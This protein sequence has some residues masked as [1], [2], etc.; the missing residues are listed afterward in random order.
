MRSNLVASRSVAPVGVVEV[1]LAPAGV[2][3]RSPAGGPRRRGRSRPRSRPAGS[4][5]RGCAR[6]RA[7]RA[8][9]PSRPAVAEAAPRAAP[10]DP[11]L[12]VG[13]V[14]KAGG[15][16][17]S[18]SARA[19]EVVPSG[20]RSV[21]KRAKPT[22]WSRAAGRLWSPSSAPANGSPRA[23]D[24]AQ[25]GA[26]R[27]A[28]PRERARLDLVPRQW[29]RHR[30]PGPRA[31]RSRRPPSCGRSRPGWSRSARRGGGS[32]PTGS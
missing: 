25:G 22:Y 17:V 29:H 30:G 27:R 23:L 24:P 11:G 31:A 16:R 4:R 32:C 2:A 1:L 3:A 15:P 20:S 9:R 18:I 21:A 7:R 12:G 6:A 19:A 13:R 28:G 14:A 5:A 8:R 26:H 10:R